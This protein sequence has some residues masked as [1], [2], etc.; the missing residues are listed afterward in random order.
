MKSNGVHPQPIASIRPNGPGT[1]FV[2]YGDCCSGIPGGSNEANFAAVNAVFQRLDTMPE[3]TFFVGDSIVGGEIPAD[4]F[5]AQWRYWIDQ[6]MAWYSGLGI[7]L[8]HV[9]SN[10]NTTN[11]VGEAVF[12][13]IHSD[14][15]LNGPG[16]QQRLSYWIRQGD[17]LYVFINTNFSGR[18]GRGYVEHEW[19]DQALTEHA[20]AR[21]KL[22]IG[23]HPI[24]GVNGYDLYPLWRVDPA[25]GKPFW[26][27]LVR[28]G[29]FA[30]V[31]SHV[32]AFDVQVHAGVL[33]L[34][35]GGAGTYG[36]G[37]G[38]MPEPCEYFHLVQGAID[39]TGLRYQVLDTSGKVREWLRWPEP[40]L[41]A[42]DPVACDPASPPPAH[43]PDGAWIARFRL[44][45]TAQ[46]A[47]HDQTMLSGWDVHEGPETLWI[48]LE[49]AGRLTVQLVPEAGHGAQRWQ[50]PALAA[51][52]LFDLE[53]GIH[54]GMGPGGVLCRT[55]GGPWSSLKSTTARGAQALAW[56]EAWALGHGQSGAADRPF[57]DADLRVASNVRSI[58]LADVSA[59]DVALKQNELLLH[60]TVSQEVLPHDAVN[61]PEDGFAPSLVMPRSRS[62]RIVRGGRAPQ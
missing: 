49:P 56:P 23:H 27:V 18:G 12:R 26:E 48:G 2:W 4:A 36:M 8:Y 37:L 17:F 20:D 19:L 31:C 3:V 34:C 1:S 25:D 51:G 10:H 35:T 7:P 22:V 43:G 41:E 54:S 38:L 53:I 60:C 13:E 61:D 11:E 46:S 24:F 59:T 9:T 28:H 21:H 40:A 45:G 15:P 44:Q 33:Q 16:V 42:G 62:N 39:A 6:E 58:S 14:I 55:P 30:Y 50:G 5:R 57:Q 32:L 29:V 47:A 52:E